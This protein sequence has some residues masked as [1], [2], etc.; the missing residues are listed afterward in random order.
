MP[1]ALGH[2]FRCAPEPLLGLDH[3]ARCE[4][5]FAASVLAQRDQVGRS[6]H[7]AHG[8]I[9]LLFSV[10]VPMHE[11]GK[12]AVRERRLTGA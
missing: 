12:V 7:R 5:L 2:Q 4:P 8:Q 9:E 3:L 10:A 1:L 11:H 6:A